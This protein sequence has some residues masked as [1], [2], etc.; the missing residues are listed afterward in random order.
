M[1]DIAVMFNCVKEKER[2]RDGGEEEN[3]FS[4]LMENNGVQSEYRN[5]DNKLDFFT[6]RERNSRR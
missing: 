1:A 6:E 2:Q 3:T 5:H 4:K